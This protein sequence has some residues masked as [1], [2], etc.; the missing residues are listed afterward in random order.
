MGLFDVHAHLTHPELLHGVDG[1]LERAEQAGVST[2][3]AN[4]LNP[5][6]NAQVAA[7]AA[8]CPKV[9]PAFGLYPVDAV[10]QDMRAAGV[11]YPGEQQAV[12]AAEGI[13]WVREHVDEAFAIGEI[14][15]DGHWVPAEFWPAQEQAFCDLVKLALEA[16]KPIIIHTRKRERRALELLDELGARR[17]N[18][19]CF[20][21]RVALAREIAGR[22][23]YLSIP[24]N[25]RRSETFTRMLETLPRTQLLLETDCP[26]LGAE[27]GSRSE[28]AQVRGT[29]QFA[30]E[31]W[32]EPLER[33][34][35]Q[36]SANFAAL[37]G[38]EP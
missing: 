26:Y 4:G 20:T 29:A 32:G 9:R 15:L 25:A 36:F 11:S 23:H 14:G 33:V 1:V 7:L 12:S 27:P 37:F 5:T 28:P 19:H 8:R 35:A 22:G 10:L 18:W 3:V 38:V 2:V 6:D 31:L 21:S 34:E 16:D 24:A 13:A 30:A 17:V